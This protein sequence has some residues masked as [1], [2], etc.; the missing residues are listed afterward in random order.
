MERK[1]EVYGVGVGVGVYGVGVGVVVVVVVLFAMLA[2]TVT[3][4]RRQVADE[5][6]PQIPASEVIDLVAPGVVDLVSVC[7]TSGVEV[8]VRSGVTREEKLKCSSNCAF[9]HIL[10]SRNAKCSKTSPSGVGS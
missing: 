8:N 5:E 6:T 7:P 9:Y 3:R 10:T 1:V 4:L 2:A